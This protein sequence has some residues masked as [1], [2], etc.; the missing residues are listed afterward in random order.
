MINISERNLLHNIFKPP[1]RNKHLNSHYSP[2]LHVCMSNRKGKGK[3]KNFR[4]LLDSV[5]SSTNVMRSLVEKLPTDKD[6]LMQWHTQADNIT[7]KIKV[8]VDITLP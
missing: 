5:C 7:T 1:K 3:F 6:I 8:E 4:I 2:I